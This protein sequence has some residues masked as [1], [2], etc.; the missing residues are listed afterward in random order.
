LLNSYHFALNIN[1]QVINA[2]ESVIIQNVQGTVHLGDEAKELLA[3]IER[4]GGNDVPLLEAAV[5]Q[6]EDKDAPPVD[7]SAAKRRLKKFLSQGAGALHDVSLD[8]LEK[9][10]EKRSACRL[11]RSRRRTPALG[12]R[13][14]VGSASPEDAIAKSGPARGRHL[15]LGAMPRGP[16]GER[17][18]AGTT[19][20]GIGGC[21]PYLPGRQSWRYT[22]G[23]R[24]GCRAAIWAAGTGFIAP[25]LWSNW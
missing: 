6:L 9:Y 22:D 3:L 19:A 1:N 24:T 25:S 5:H 8:L 20:S 23:D 15:V 18:R 14:A 13:G 7:R 21:L 4:F 10:L 17:E 2:M 16:V 12:H 11:P